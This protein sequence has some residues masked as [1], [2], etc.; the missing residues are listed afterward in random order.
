M[1][2]VLSLQDQKV[3]TGCGRSS[4]YIVVIINQ[5]V[6]GRNAIHTI[7]VLYR[8]D[9]GEGSRENSKE[10]LFIFAVTGSTEHCLHVLVEDV[11]HTLKKGLELIHSGSNI[12]FIPNPALTYEQFGIL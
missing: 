7:S 4:T 11:I 3:I 1:V 8:H 10:G 9:N 5:C 12:P 2:T 6:V